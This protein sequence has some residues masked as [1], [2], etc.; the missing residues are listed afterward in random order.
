M[1]IVFDETN[2]L[3]AMVGEAHGL[4]PA[5]YKAQMR[6]GPEVVNSFRKLVERGEVG[7]PKLPF[8]T[9]MLKEIQAFARKVRGSYDAVCLLGI[10]GSA[11]GAWALD[12]ALRGPHPV[13]KAFSTK[14]PR[15]VILD[16]VDPALVGAALE[17]MDPRRTLVLPITKQ[18]TTAETAAALF[19]VR[20]WLGKR[21]AKQTVAVTTPGRG[22]LYR[23][24][25]RENWPVFAIPENVGGRFSVLSPVGLLPAALIGLD[26]AALLRGAAQMTEICWQVDARKNPALRAAL[27]HE[28]IWRAKG[29]TI[30]VAFAYSNRLW[31]MAFW[32]RQLWAESLG[33]ART[34]GGENVSIGQ[35]PVAAL[36]VTDQHSQ[37]QLY[38][39]GPNDKVFSFWAVSRHDWEGRIPKKK[40]KLEAFDYLV[41]RKLAELL[42]AERLSTEAAL[43]DASRPNCTYTLERVDEEHVGAF[44]QLLEFQTA[45]IAELLDVNAFDQ[46]GVEAGKRFT[47]GLMGRPGFE[48][49]RERFEQY[50]KRRRQ[51][52]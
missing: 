2:L 3:S 33:K 18:G 12:C 29:K 19:I 7:F 43:T 11:L 15:L 23:L 21:A 42:E 13:Q 4:T 49:Y 5:E 39:E 8:D 1:R 35:T 44:L 6:R 22:D 32:F 36:G 30:Q 38:V 27:L 24:A 9:G 28:A 48:E 31:G 45:F 26:V 20:E 52:L 25:L 40:L 10:G 17:S 50:Q 34:R 16:N 14:N 37:V 46:P 41:G 47:Y 51:A